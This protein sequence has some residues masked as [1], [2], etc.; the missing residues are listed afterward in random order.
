MS[1]GSKRRPA[2]VDAKT[3]EENFDRIFGRGR[4]DK[5]DEITY[6]CKT[7]NS[8]LEAKNV[9]KTYYKETKYRRGEEEYSC[10]LCG[11]PSIEPYDFQDLSVDEKLY[12]N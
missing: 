4:R 5:C 3:Y 12:L 9:T 6:W 8:P 2:S 11:F 7:C 1:K 10:K